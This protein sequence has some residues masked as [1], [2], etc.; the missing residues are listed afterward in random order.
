[1]RQDEG[2]FEGIQSKSLN[3]AF[4]LRMK[5]AILANCVELRSAYATNP[6]SIKTSPLAVNSVTP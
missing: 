3:V 5:S 4:L 6:R 2:N 1:M